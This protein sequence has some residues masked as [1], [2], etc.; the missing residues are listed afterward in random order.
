MILNDWVMDP[1]V[2]KTVSYFKVST[3]IV[4]LASGLVIN[5][6]FLQETKRK[7]K[8]IRIRLMVFM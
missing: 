3:V 5:V 2:T 8:D 7:Q 6:S 1:A 4:T